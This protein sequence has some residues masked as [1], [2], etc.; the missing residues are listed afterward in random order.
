[1]R[2]SARECVDEKERAKLHGRFLKE[3]RE[4][5]RGERTYPVGE[6]GGMI[7]DIRPARDLIQG[8]VRDAAALAGELFALAKAQAPASGG[9]RRKK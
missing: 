6:I 4:A 7:R 5:T 9:S 8:I 2:P 1:M 3:L